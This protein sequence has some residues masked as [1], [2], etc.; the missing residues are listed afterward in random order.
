[1]SKKKQYTLTLLA[2]GNIL[3]DL[4]YGIYA[5]YWW[6]PR[7]FDQTC[8]PQTPTHLNWPLSTRKK[9]KRTLVNVLIYE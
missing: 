9:H 1:M 4:H 3:Q 6:E 7:K 5:R 2:K 8:P